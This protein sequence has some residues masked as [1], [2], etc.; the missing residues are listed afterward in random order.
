MTLIASAIVNSRLVGSFSIFEVEEEEAE[1]TSSVL[2]IVCK[3]NIATDHR[4]PGGFALHCHLYVYHV[5][6]ALTFGQ[7]LLTCLYHVSFI[8]IT[9]IVIDVMSISAS[10]TS[11]K[12]FRGNCH[13]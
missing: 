4:Q 1:D 13:F 2:S 6:F 10:Q 3:P 12:F 9:S 7:F 11:H 8:Y 5:F